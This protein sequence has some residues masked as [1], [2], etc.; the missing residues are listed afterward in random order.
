MWVRGHSRSLKLVPFESLGTVSYSPS[1]VTIAVSVAVCE[2]FIVKEWRDLQSQ[3]TG[4]STSLKM[5][6]FDRPYATFYWS[7]ITNIALSCTIFELFDV[8]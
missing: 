2:I 3:V 7:A 4:H 5:A 8:E 6:Q 1:I